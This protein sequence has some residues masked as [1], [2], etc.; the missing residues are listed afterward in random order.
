[1][2]WREVVSVVS[3]LVATNAAHGQI[4]SCRDASGKMITSDRP[5]PECN[6]R[7]VRELNKDGSVKREIQP[8]MTAEQRRK[9]EAE[10]AKAKADELARLEQV[11]K[12]KAMLATYAKES[13]LELARARALKASE[14]VIKSV[15]TRIASIAK[16][17]KDQAGEAEFYKGKPLPASLKQRM[18][19]SA[20]SLKR[21]NALIEQQKDEAAKINARFDEEL[22]RYRIITGAAATEADKKGDAGKADLARP[23]AAKTAKP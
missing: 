17:Q 10:E 15:Q 19:E 1:M 7:T 16:A 13:D 14:D 23:A 18:D 8:Q 4:Y 6:D 2:A 22:K 21:E 5:I 9:A 12:D 20:A 11:R 3:L